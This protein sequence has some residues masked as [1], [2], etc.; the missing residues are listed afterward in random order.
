M[1]SKRRNANGEGTIYQ[2]KKGKHKNKWIGQITIGINPDTGKPK[3]KSFYGKSRGEV[4]E[5][6]RDYM[7]ELGKGIDL[8][9]QEQTFGEWILSWMENYKRIDLRLST[10]ENY[11]R[12]IKNHIYPALGYIPLKDLKTDDLQ[13]LY[14]NMTKEGLAPATVRRNHQIIHSCLKQAVSNRLLSWNPA[15]AVK[16]PKLTKPTVRAMTVNEMDA[17]LSA[18]E[19]DRWGT[20]FLCLLGTGL[21]TGELLAL[22]WQDV[23]LDKQYIHI[24]QTLVRTK[25]KGLY[26]DEPK[27]E[28]SKRIVP[29]PSEVAAAL[30][31]HRI[32][33]LELRVFQGEKYQNNDLVFATSKGTPINPRNFI[34]K[35]HKIRDNVG[36]SKEVNLHA[37]RH[38]Y[39][40]RLLEEGEN[41]KIV[42]ELLGHTKISTT[43]DTYSH[44]SAEVKAKA[45][46]KMDKLLMR[47]TGSN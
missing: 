31:K 16:L 13:R 3:R 20:A 23:D 47:G 19:A 5:K 14:N 25:E 30:K 21:R 40:T 11:M 22:R 39:A 28:K 27:T 17:F 18:L 26:F 8:I 9:G 37:L 33:Q 10:W 1:S 44:V 38:T 2:C 12:S 36:I 6:M 29:L 46:A 43:A 4:K 34:R 15:E 45:A 41:L 7:E 42:Q 32:E 24:K 35:F